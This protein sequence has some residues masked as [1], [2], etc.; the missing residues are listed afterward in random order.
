MKLFG[1][2]ITG[3][4]L[5]KMD[6]S[7]PGKKR[8]SVRGHIW[9]EN[10]FYRIRIEGSRFFFINDRGHKVGVILRGSLAYKKIKRMIAIR[11]KKYRTIP[12]MDGTSYYRSKCVSHMTIRKPNLLKQAI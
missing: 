6:F 4:E 2:E 12:F 11:F 8:I 10:S 3:R 5:Y 9:L 7:V 1:K